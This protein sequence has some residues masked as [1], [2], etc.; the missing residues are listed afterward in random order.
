MKYFSLKNKLLISIALVFILIGCSKAVMNDID[1]MIKSNF[2]NYTKRN[3]LTVF[4]MPFKPATKFDSESVIGIIAWNGAVDG[5]KD[6]AFFSEGRLVYKGLVDPKEY[7]E[8]LRTDDFW[9]DMSSGN[10]EVKDILKIAADDYGVNSIIYGLYQGSE[11][12]LRLTVYFYSRRDEI[13]LKQ[14]TYAKSSLAELRSFIR[15]IQNDEELSSSHKALLR[16]I[17]EKMQIVTT[18]LLRKYMEGV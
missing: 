14:K 17:Q 10:R 12:E 6:S 3:P 18:K 9:N 8:V 15:K 11:A 2:G 4:V 7:L 13:I 1:Q 16:M 5:V